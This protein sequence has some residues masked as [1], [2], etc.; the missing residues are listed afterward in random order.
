MANN[1]D[2]GKVL[3]EELTWLEEFGVGMFASQWLAVKQLR[4]KTCNL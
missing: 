1:S 3:F 2:Y 4:E